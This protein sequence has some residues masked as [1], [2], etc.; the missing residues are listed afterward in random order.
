MDGIDVALIRTDG[1]NIIEHGLNATYE[2]D[3][4][5]RQKLS[6]AMADAVA[7]SHRDER[8]GDLAEVEREVT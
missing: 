5:T 8:P 4:I 2:F 6:A 1:Q 3:A 7:I